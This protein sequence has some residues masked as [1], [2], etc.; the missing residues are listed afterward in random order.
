MKANKDNSEIRMTFDGDCSIEYK[1]STD[2][3]VL[4]IPKVWRENGKQWRVT[5][6][7]LPYFSHPVVLKKPKSCLLEGINFNVTQE[8]YD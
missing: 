2:I 7:W 3:R 1:G 5:N 6:V 4:E 8:D